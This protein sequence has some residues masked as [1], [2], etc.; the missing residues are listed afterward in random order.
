MSGTNVVSDWKVE[1]SI[2]Y[3]GIWEGKEYEDKGTI[4][5]IEPEKLFQSTYWSSMSGTKDSPENYAT[6]TYE[7]S[8][9]DGGTKIKVTQDNCGTKDMK[10]PCERNREIVLNGMKKILES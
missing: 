2:I 3:N 7:L 1:S 5:K 9:E 10:Q 6:V 8:K 4:L